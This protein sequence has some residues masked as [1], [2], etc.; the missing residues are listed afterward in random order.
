M[1]YGGV[2]RA[3]RK[4][5]VIAVVADA[6]P[7][8]GVGDLGHADRRGGANGHQVARLLDAPAQRVRAC[9]AAIE[10]DEALL[11]EPGAL[12]HAE[13]RIELDRRR[14]EPVLQRGHVDDRLERRAW[15]TERL[16]RS[17][18]A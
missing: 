8:R 12:P 11:A 13:R 6:E 3:E 2:A 16:D 14:G 1:E 9:R 7:A 4:G 5:Q 10:I 18:I 17:V 15:L